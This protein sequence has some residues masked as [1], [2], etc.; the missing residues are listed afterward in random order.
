MLSTCMRSALINVGLELR[1]R[2]IST[3]TSEIIMGLVHFMVPD[4]AIK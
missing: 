3:V 2:V 1:K 4:T